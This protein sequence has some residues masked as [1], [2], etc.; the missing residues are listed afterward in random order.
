MKRSTALKYPVLLLSL[1]GAVFVPQAAR[2]TS[3]EK[4][5]NLSQSIT[6]ADVVFVGQHESFEMVW[7]DCTS[8]GCKSFTEGD[9]GYYLV[10][11]TYAADEVWK[12][13]LENNKATIISS[14]PIPPSMEEAF[15]EEAIE[16]AKKK[17]KKVFAL[18]KVKIADDKSSAV[19]IEHPEKFEKYY[20]DPVCGG[21]YDATP[22]S[23]Q[24]L[25]KRFPK[26][27]VQ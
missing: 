15:R 6:N 25:Q 17:D 23:M 4:I 3:C 5:L 11:T 9:K 12:G 2:A 8:D 18:K 19:K 10:A 20:Q 7:V 27:P 14:W 26:V 16:F 13:T 24:T 21:E 22:E 1:F